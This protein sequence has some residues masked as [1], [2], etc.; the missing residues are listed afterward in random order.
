M[1]H[2]NVETCKSPAYSLMYGAVP[3]APSQDQ[4]GSTP[5]RP[6]GIVSA[7][8]PLDI[9]EF[10]EL[11]VEFKSLKKERIYECGVTRQELAS[12]CGYVDIARLLVEHGTDVTAQAE[13]SP[14]FSVAKWKYGSLT[15]LIKHGADVTA[16]NKGVLIPL[17]PGITSGD[18][19][20][21]NAS[22]SIIGKKLL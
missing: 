11:I 17:T 16:E 21:L 3:T 1:W 14:A 7:S 20:M 15:F 10:I 4:N 13:D 22:L 12:L 5:L 9:F 18:T 2:Q 8:A 6:S 19:R